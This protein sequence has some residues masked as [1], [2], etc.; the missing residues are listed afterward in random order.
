MLNNQTQFSGEYHNRLY[1]ITN[2][3][4]RNFRAVTFLP[5]S[6]NWKV[7]TLLYCQN[8]QAS[9]PS[10]SSSAQ[11]ATQFLEGSW[12]YL[13]DIFILDS[14]EPSFYLHILSTNSGSELRRVFWSTRHS[15]TRILAS[16]RWQH[17]KRMTT[18]HGCSRHTQ[19]CKQ[20]L[21]PSKW[22]FKWCTTTDSI[23]VRWA[24]R[25]TE[26][27]DNSTHKLVSNSCCAGDGTGFRKF[28][29]LNKASPRIFKKRH[30]FRKVLS[31]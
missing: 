14:K 5:C 29:T 24:W 4:K 1:Y 16:R 20:I 22:I 17:R 19:D 25:I 6:E 26:L 15:R 30:I 11:K 12:R 8:W 9:E 13:I 28:E 2:L 27:G 18:C 31:L 3:K 7:W 10:P 21:K 23:H